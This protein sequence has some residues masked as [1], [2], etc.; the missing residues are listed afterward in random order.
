M[1]VKRRENTAPGHIRDTRRELAR[2]GLGKPTSLKHHFSKPGNKP[3]HSFPWQTGGVH[4]VEWT[5][6]LRPPQVTDSPWEDISGLHH[7]SSL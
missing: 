5:G 7:H 1:I 2:R 6:P 4:R 3:H